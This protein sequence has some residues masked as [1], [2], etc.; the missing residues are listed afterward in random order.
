[1]NY[2]SGTINKVKNSDLGQFS[3]LLF[4]AVEITNF[5]SWTSTRNVFASHCRYHFE[6]L[7][8]EASPAS[9]TSPPCPTARH[10]SGDDDPSKK[11][12]ECW[13]SAVWGWGDF[14]FIVFFLLF[15]TCIG[16][17]WGYCLIARVFLDII[18]F[19]SFMTYKQFCS[20]YLVTQSWS[21][22]L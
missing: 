16:A 19:R 14:Y 22:C 15:L 1:M 8:D 12:G 2:T 17:C 10:P 5:M 20:E 6:Y 3:E 21:F 7:R 13:P 4:C 11:E 18:V 9:L